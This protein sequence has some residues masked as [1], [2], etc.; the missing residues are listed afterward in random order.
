MAEIRSPYDDSVIAAVPDMDEAQVRAALSRAAQAQKPLAEMPAHRRGAI[1][2]AAAR[3]LEQQSEETARIMAR[4]SG[5][6]LKY[7]RGEVARGV[8]TFNIAADEARRLHGETIPMDAV[9]GG[10]GRI[11][12]YV[13]VPVGIIG[14]ITPFNFPLNLVAHKVAPAIAAGCPIVLKPAPQ[15]PLTALR[16]AEIVREAGL[17]EGGF[18]VVTGGVDVG[19]WLTTD[20]RV[21]MISFTGSVPVAHEISKTAGIRRVTLELG[22]NA[23]TVIDADANLTAAVNRTVW[24]SFAYSGQV[25]ISVQRIYV[26]SS[27]YDEF[28]EQFIGTTRKLVMGDPLDEKTDIGPLVSDGAAARVEAWI[29]EAVEQ[30]AQIAVGG[31]RAGRMFQPTVLEKVDPAMQ[32][33]CNEVFGP[34]VSLIPFDD[35]EAALAQADD[36]TFGLQAGV[37][38]HN[39]NHAMRAVQRLNVGGVMINDVPTF[40]IDQMPYGGMKDS[41]VG[42]EGPRFAIEEMTNLKMVVINTL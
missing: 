19:R 20:A 6:P 3:M 35:F 28:R 26:H 5:K 32:V 30:G 24:G 40:R 12:Y 31:M 1:L 36:S 8:D 17:P 29:R 22:G 34:V 42:R 15:T 2:N 9:A 37:Y 27:R 18:E 4:E 39:L 13:R 7:T 23:A 25:C 14:A 33:M 16:L 21:A 10:V 38:T 41:G 11:G